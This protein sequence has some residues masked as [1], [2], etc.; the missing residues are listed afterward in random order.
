MKQPST[1]KQVFL[2]LTLLGVLTYGWT[3]FFGFSYLDDNV[4]ILDNL[5]FIQNLANI[6]QAFILEV[7]HVLHASAA[8]YRPMLTLSFMLDASLSGAHPF[9]YHLSNIIYHLVATILVYLFLKKMNI[10]AKLSF[11]FAAVFA[12]HPVLAQAVAWIPGRNDS[13]LTI[14]ALLAFIYFLNYLE[15]N[16]LGDFGKHLLFFALALFTKE[17][18]VF[19]LPLLF[20]YVLFIL[21]RK[22][23]NVTI[24]WFFG[25]GTSFII[26]FILRRIA[27]VNPINYS[28]PFIANSITNNF[29]AILLFLGKILFPFNLS[30]LP[31]L[32]DSSL[33]P[34][35][36]SLVLL[37]VLLL[38][39]KGK[40]IK[41]MLFGIVWF[42]VFLVP[43]FI[44][45]DLSYIPDFLEHRVYL[46]MIGFFIVISQ[47]KL[48]RANQI[49]GSIIIGVLIIINFLHLP[50]YKN[51]MNFWQNAAKTSPSHPLAHKNLGSM[52]L[53]DGDYQ[54]A[55]IEYAK[56]L[57]INPQESMVHNNLGVIYMNQG[58]KAKAEEEFR[59]ELV[60]NPNYDKALNNL[61]ILLK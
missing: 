12:V 24:L 29:P 27:L 49:V 38:L 19:I 53:F 51:R 37:T 5:S 18:A 13:L 7:F 41:L 4:L 6:P 56:A 10:S 44:R 40:D 30:V 2:W 57:Q 55:E 59:K 42:L 25:W 28:L 23:T 21:K 9:F 52:Y 54:R 60:I 47:I 61:E 39:S 35:L 26:W 8:Y 43:S 17:S 16:R 32:V 34:G 1:N 36:I 14:F 15:T 48:I 22:F 3:V 33:I 45:P 20:I 31:T 50:V 11:F 46:S 58:N